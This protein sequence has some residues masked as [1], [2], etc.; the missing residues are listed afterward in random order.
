MNLPVAAS[1]RALKS[2]RP[3]AQRRADDARQVLYKPRVEMKK[4]DAIAPCRPARVSIVRLCN[5]LISTYNNTSTNV[6]NVDIVNVKKHF[7]TKENIQGTLGQSVQVA[8]LGN[9]STPSKDIQ[10]CTRTSSVRKTTPKS[11]SGRPCRSQDTRRSIDPRV[12]AADAKVVDRAG[13][14]SASVKSKD[15]RHFG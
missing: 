10:Y 3:A 8:R 9:P 4:L 13:K 2:E 12:L 1:R 15:R 7:Y 11:N 5:T 14:T 6:S